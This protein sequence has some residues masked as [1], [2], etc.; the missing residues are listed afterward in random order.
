MTPSDQLPAEDHP[1][2]DESLPS[3]RGTALLRA[4]EVMEALRAPD[5]DAWTHRQT[6]ASLAR[7]LLE[8]THEVL[9][10][11]DTPAAHGSTALTDELGDL[12][13][14]ILF[15]ARI[16]QD[17]DPAWDVDDVA[18]SFIAKMERRNPH[19]FGEDRDRALHD[20]ADVDEIIAQ[21]HAV[22]AAEQEA[23]G[24][25][26][27]GW[28]DSIPAGLPSLQTAAKAVHRARSAGRLE[29]LLESADHQVD[30]EDR[31]DWGGDIGRALLDVVVAA[32]ARDIDPESALRSLLARMR[33]QGAAPA[34]DP[35]SL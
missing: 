23:S 14:Q 1:A 28:F 17:E 29:E 26:R 35:R 24:G 3:P 20:R 12:L 32:E 13:F 11:I 25:R 8:E 5:G 7:Y 31:E 22:K 9:E 27:T 19:I 33:A 2:S 30:T 4:V 21:W 18:R 16:G 6:H 10:V 34:D 15:H